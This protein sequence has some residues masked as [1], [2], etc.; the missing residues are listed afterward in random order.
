[1]HS[2]DIEPDDVCTSRDA[3]ATLRERRPT[4]ANKDEL[5]E[6]MRVT[7][8]DRRNWIARRRPTA[9][10]ITVRYPRL[11]DMPDAVSEPHIVN[12]VL[13]CGPQ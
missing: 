7:R 4:T 3:E 9:T 2:T 8:S 5:L 10:D 11:L 13:I 12:E 6:L 1:M